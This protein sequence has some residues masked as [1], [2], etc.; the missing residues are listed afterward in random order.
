MSN[1]N[2]HNFTFYDTLAAAKREAARTGLGLCCAVNTGI[3]WSGK[4][5]HVWYGVAE[6]KPVDT[7]VPRWSVVSRMRN[8]H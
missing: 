7:R 8:I 1:Y 5:H 6:A 2:T 3:V 4:N